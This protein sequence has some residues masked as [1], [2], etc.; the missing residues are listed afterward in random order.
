M[1]TLGLSAPNDTFRPGELERMVGLGVRVFLLY[2]WDP[3]NAEHVAEWYDVARDIKRQ[4]PDAVLHV[5]L[6]RRGD[7]GNA[8]E[9]AEQLAA[10]VAYRPD[11]ASSTFGELV[12]SWRVGN[13][14]NI[15]SPA[16]APAQWAIWQV[17]ML[18]RARIVC[19]KGTQ[20]FV[21][22]LSPSDQPSGTLDEWLFAAVDA[23]TTG[24]FDGM[25]CH[26]YGPPAVQRDVLRKYRARWLKRL[27]ITES[28]PGAGNAFSHAQ[29]AADLP[30]TLDAAREVGAEA[31][32]LFIA[33]W[34]NPDTALPTPV[35]ILGSAP[36]EAAIRALAKATANAHAYETAKEATVIKGLA[37]WVWYWEDRFVDLAERV[38]ATTLLVKAADGVSRWAQWPVA[39]AKC[40]E[41]GIR[42]V[43]WS[44]NYGHPGE[45]EALVRVCERT[46]VDTF[47]IDPEIEFERLPKA[48]QR[49]F[50]EMVRAA[51]ARGYRVGC[52]TW[53]RPEA[54][55]AYRFDYLSEVVDVWLPMVAWMAWSPRMAAHWLDHWDT[56]NYGPTAPWLPAY[57]VGSDELAASVQLALERYGAATLWAAHEMTEGDVTALEA[58][59]KQAKTDGQQDD[60]VT[61]FVR[62]VGAT[63]NVADV[64]H[65]LWALSSGQ[66]TGGDPGAAA[67]IEAAV[68]RIKQLVG[69]Q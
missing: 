42:P 6:E 23:A 35:D 64:L 52:A 17:V 5:R 34:H 62:Q 46:N 39:A 43:P 8:F 60:P 58:I 65:L 67:C 29:W 50:V 22:A 48:K 47:I 11:D 68:I 16:L 40:R 14:S 31:L 3:G 30:A 4:R 10:I 45:I 63:G 37:L 9:A 21:P 24:S 20:I 66:R 69:L 53:A 19:P 49:A 25:D 36:M 38:G 13:E 61:A 44:Y 32:I 55:G 18:R 33:R 57:A 12:A 2:L 59:R 51:K 41:A 54:H 1:T 26:A 28:N 7:L 27:L 56:F 15:E